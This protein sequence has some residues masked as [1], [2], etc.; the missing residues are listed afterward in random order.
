M[1]GGIIISR[2]VGFWY[3]G[4]L[5]P[6]IGLVQ[7]GMQAMADRFT[8]VP[9][10]GLFI[11]IAWGGWEVASAKKLPT[12]MLGAIMAVICVV[13]MALTRVQLQYWKD[14]KA[15]FGR[16]ISATPNNYMAHYNLGNLYSRE[17]NL[18]EAVANY[19]KAIEYE[20]NYANA[21][22]NLGG[23]LLRQKKYGE[24]VE[25]YKK[26]LQIIP[27]YIHYF[28]LANA[29]GDSGRLT[30]AEDYYRQALNLNPNSFE[31]YNNYGMVLNADKKFGEAIAAFQT[32]SASNR[33]LNWAN[34]T[35]PMPSPPWADWTTP[36]PTTP[37]PFA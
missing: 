22:N 31:T 35:W 26:A 1:R 13:C 10:I 25:H 14:S 7:V 28:N 8:Y 12:M 30:E 19:E 16:M 27:E 6:V 4:T 18:P 17:E 33:I 5:V 3:V 24:A 34:S 21:H 20:P 9:M 36:S 2:S 15:L 11:I 37:S 29:L 32:P 23:V